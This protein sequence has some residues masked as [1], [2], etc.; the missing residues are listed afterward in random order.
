LALQHSLN[1]GKK[2]GDAGYV[3]LSEALR[4]VQVA[5]QPPATTPAAAPQ[6]TRLDALTTTVQS[7]EQKLTELRARRAELAREGALYG[8]DLD[9]L[10]NQIDDTVLALAEARAEVKVESRTVEQTEK[11]RERQVYEQAIQA[12]TAVKEKA[13][14]Q[15]PSAGVKDSPLY[16]EIKRMA[17]EMNNPAHPDHGI[18]GTTNAAITVT[19]KAAIA[20]AQRL[21]AEKG[22]SFAQEFEALQAPKAQAGS[23]PPAQAPAQPQIPPKVL[24]G[25]G[26]QQPAVQVPEK[27]PTQIL[28]EVGTDPAAIRAALA[29]RRGQAEMPVLR[30]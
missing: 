30:L 14:Q 7:H 11:E 9:S 25:M 16:S 24:P 8:E 3:P 15:Y 29:A 10:Q 20:V 12:R 23:T 28:A 2:P 26:R 27:T 1:G 18:L 22:T 19:E 4:Q 13:L 21:S 5:D 6:P 17:A